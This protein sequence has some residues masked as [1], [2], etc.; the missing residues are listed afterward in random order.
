MFD[1]DA[2]TDED[3]NGE[4][5]FYWED[6]VVQMGFDYNK[7]LSKYIKEHDGYLYPH[8]FDGKQSIDI[9]GTACIDGKE[10]TPDRIVDVK[11]NN[12]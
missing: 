5:Y 2:Y 3:E 11:I 12:N 1:F 8:D 7:K 4:T 10:L 9:L 6:K